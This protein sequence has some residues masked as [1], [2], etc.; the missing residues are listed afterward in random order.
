MAEPGRSKLLY[1]TNP[2][3]SKGDVDVFRFFLFLAV[4]LAAVG[5]VGSFGLKIV[6]EQD[7][8]DDGFEEL[9]RSGILDGSA[10]FTPTARG[11]DRGNYGAIERDDPFENQEGEGAELDPAKDPEEEEARMKKTWVLNAETRRFLTDG[12]HVVFLAR[13]L[14]HDR[15][16]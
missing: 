13:L 6:D 16:C 2:D 12:N 8:I 9:E 3:G 15:A 4:L 1:E 11:G 10:L 7:L 5:V 14:P